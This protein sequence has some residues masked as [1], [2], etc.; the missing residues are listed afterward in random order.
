MLIYG[1]QEGLQLGTAVPGCPMAVAACPACPFPTALPRTSV[2]EKLYFTYYLMKVLRGRARRT[3][4]G[5]GAAVPGAAA[6]VAEP[7]C[8]IATAT[9][10]HS[11]APALAGQRSTLVLILFQG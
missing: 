11:R 4:L 7:R 6:V 8:P 10:E 9:G 1:S 3:D 5:E 2:A